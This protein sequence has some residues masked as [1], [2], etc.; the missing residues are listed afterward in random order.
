MNLS[1]KGQH[2]DVGDALRAH[3]EEKLEVVK[4]KYFNRVTDATVLFSKPAEY[5]FRANVT[6]HVGH[7]V[8]VQATSENQDPYSAFDEA[9]DRVAK[10]L[11]RYKT[12]LRD[13]HERLEKTPDMAFLT[14]RDYILQTEGVDID[15]EDAELNQMPAS[16]GHDHLVVAEMAVNIPSLSVPDAVMRLDLANADFLLFKNPKSGALNIVYRRPDGNIG[17]VDPSLAEAGKEG[18]A[19]TKAA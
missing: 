6:F 1:V 2:V 14:A 5:L 16:D 11:R 9:A 10:Q 13:H 17:W 15:D 18:K 19:K 8:K 3:I 7:D 12:R 4:S